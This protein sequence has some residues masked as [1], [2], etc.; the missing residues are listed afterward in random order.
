ML[1][2]LVTYLENLV[3]FIPFFMLN[4]RATDR[5]YFSKIDFYLLYVLLFDIVNGQR[6]YTI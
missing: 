4:N 6:Q 1:G 5:Q 2:A 3:L